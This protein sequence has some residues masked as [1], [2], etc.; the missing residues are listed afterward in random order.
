ME[1][2][3]A[4]DMLHSMIPFV[5]AIDVKVECAEPGGVRLALEKN[6]IVKNHLDTIH[7]GAIFSLAE[8]TGGLAVLSHPALM[9]F[10]ILAKGG[11]ISYK[12]PIAS[13]A[14][15]TTD[16]SVDAAAAF[17]ADVER[18]GKADRTLDIAILNEKQELAVEVS[19]DYHLRKRK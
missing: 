16:F 18:D 1:P 19:M 7:A 10:E 13:K 9:K 2:K 17:A 12:R 5:K 15:A 4:E 11:R 8:T 14:T 6:A 3:Q